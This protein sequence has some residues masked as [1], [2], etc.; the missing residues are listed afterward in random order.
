M[1]TPSYMN[2]VAP[3]SSHCIQAKPLRRTRLGISSTGIL[4]CLS[5]LGIVPLAAAQDPPPSLAQFATDGDLNFAPIL[6]Y[7]T[8][9]C[10]NVPAIGFDANNNIIVA[11]GLENLDTSLTGGCRDKADLD[12]TNAYSRQRCNSGWCAYMY[13]Y[14][15]EKDVKYQYSNVADNGH[16]HDWEHI[17]VW[18]EQVSIPAS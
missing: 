1:S 13:D 4:L 11:Q 12:N 17:I 10:Y 7:D 18:V 6:D 9:S 5:I 8:D 3:T 2:R 14:Y 16:R 15:F